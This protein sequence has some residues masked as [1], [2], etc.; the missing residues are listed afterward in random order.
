MKGNMVFLKTRILIV[1]F[2]YSDDVINYA[3]QQTFGITIDLQNI[4]CSGISDDNSNRDELWF[5]NKNNNEDDD[6]EI[7]SKLMTGLDI[8]IM[9]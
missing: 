6:F 2:K 7:D 1:Y 9:Y 8:Y 4:A 5:Y 3:K